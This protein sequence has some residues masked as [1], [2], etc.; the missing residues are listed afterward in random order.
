MQRTELLAALCLM[1][2]G[3][4]AKSLFAFASES[5]EL[6]LNK[7]AGKLLREGEVDSRELLE[8]IRKLRGFSAMGSGFSDIHPG[9]ILEKLEDESP[10]VLGLLCRSLTG[11]KIKYLMEH[12]PESRR[13][14]M[15]KLNESYQVAPQ[16]AEIVRTLSEKKLR[17]AIPNPGGAFSLPH[18][19]LLK[20]DDLRTL[21]RD[22]G[23]EEIR[24]A[25]TGVEPQV[26]RAFLA[27]FVPAMAREIRERIDRGS[28]IAPAARAAAQRH[29]VSVPL[30]KLPVEE[31]FREIGYSAFAQALEVDDK[32]WADMLYHKLPPEEGYRLKRVMQDT[33]KHRPSSALEE[34]RQEILGRVADL[35]QKGKIRK[36]W[37]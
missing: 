20:T 8:R 13:K 3:E 35:A 7:L 5:D 29:L 26:L 21:F 31:L 18:L 1:N 24:K 12:M 32:P 36:Y 33:V 11:D 4:G 2:E 17:F 25:F 15:P 23:L 19:T 28:A 10:R 6:E 22:L 30:E 9:W 37:K 14:V 27:R 16:V 34:R